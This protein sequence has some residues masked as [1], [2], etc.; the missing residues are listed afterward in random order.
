[1]SNQKIIKNTLFLYFRLFF[2]VIVNLLTTKIVLN[3]LGVLDFGIYSVIGGVVVLISFFVNALVSSTQRNLSFD[4]SGDSLKKINVTFNASV[5]IHIFFSFIVLF[6]GILL[7]DYIVKSF[8]NI[9]LDRVEAA[10]IVFYSVLSIFIIRLLIIPYQSLIIAKERMEIIALHDI[11]DSLIKLS[12]AFLIVFFS[13]DK[14]KIY[15]VLMLLGVF[16]ISNIYIIYCKLNFANYCNLNLTK[17]KREVYERIG[18]FVGWT[19]FGALSWVIRNQGMAVVLNIFLGPT[20]NASFGIG[21]Q[22]SSQIS[23]FSSSLLKAVNPQIVMSYGKKNIVNLKRLLF[24]ACKFSFYLFTFISIPLFIDVKLVLSFWLGEIPEYAQ[25]FVKLFIITSMI[26]VLIGPM[27]TA[28]QATGIIKNYQIT[29]GMVFIISVP[30]SYFMLYKGFPPESV[31]YISMISTFLVGVIRLGFIKKLLNITPNDW[32]K[33][34]FFKGILVLGIDFIFYKYFLSYLSSF[35]EIEMLI[36]AIKI[37]LNSIF[38]LSLIF[39]VGIDSEEK[40]V[41]QLWVKRKLK[42]S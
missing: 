26:D 35:S 37:T 2:V 29:S 20:V 32:L 3:N 42:I 9:P 34:V 8:L 6:I 31:L 36:F 4:L 11:L 13:F 18:S 12:V 33:Q 40:K 23:N 22:V 15:S 5:R 19:I 30:V 14:L 24:A 10:Y 25:I 1:M 28:I 21:N 38:L 16:L 39:I 41:I 17:I 7:G 27:I